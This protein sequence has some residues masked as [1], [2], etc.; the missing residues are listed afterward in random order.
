MKIISRVTFAALDRL[1]LLG[2]QAVVR[3]WLVCGV[4]VLSER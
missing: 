3:C 1:E 2:D 4:R